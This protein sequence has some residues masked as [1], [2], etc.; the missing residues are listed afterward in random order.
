MRKIKSPITKIKK[1]D[2]YYCPRCNMDTLN[3]G[4]RWLPCPR[5]GCEAIILGQIKTTSII[6]V[7]LF[8]EDKIN[9]INTLK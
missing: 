7:E 4:T 9:R 1:A 8:N 6:E 3:K 5:G 2:M